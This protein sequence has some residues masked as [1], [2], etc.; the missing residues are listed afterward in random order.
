LSAFGKPRGGAVGGRSKGAP[1][2]GMHFEVIPM[3]V[4]GRL[5][6]K[7]VG[8]G[9]VA[10]GVGGWLKA[11]P[12]RPTCKAPSGVSGPSTG[13]RMELRPGGGTKPGGAPTSP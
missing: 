6:D 5:A 11:M 3:G 1:P 7:R 2:L 9:T 8:D 4:A 13:G 10:C 12:S